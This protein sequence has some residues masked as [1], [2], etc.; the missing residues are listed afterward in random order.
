MGRRI[1]PRSA[2]TEIPAPFAENLCWLLSRASYALTTELTADMEELDVSPRQQSVLEAAM[3]G[4]H[5]QIELAR[6]VGLDKTTMVVT[7]DEL[8]AAGLA[9]RRPASDD[10]RAWVIVVTS[11]G[12]QMVHKAQKVADRIRDEILNTLPVSQRKAFMESLKQ[13]VTDRL[14]EP[15]V[16]AHP[17]RRRAPRV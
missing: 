1:E 10:R 14:S 8:E 3:T 4:D 7:L 11:A 16:C 2:G 6:M 15:V 17:V 9:E 5:T 12:K 13:L